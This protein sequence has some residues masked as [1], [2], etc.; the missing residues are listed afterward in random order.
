MIIFLFVI[1]LK[2]LMGGLVLAYITLPVP[3][4]EAAR[5]R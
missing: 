2:E 1:A 5:K 3:L 4:L